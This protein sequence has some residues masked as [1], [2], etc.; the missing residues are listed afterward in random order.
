ME[1]SG[2]EL[3]FAALASIRKLQLTPPMQALNFKLVVIHQPF[4]ICWFLVQANSC[5]NIHLTLI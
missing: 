5:P 4:D 1:L 3:I 2:D